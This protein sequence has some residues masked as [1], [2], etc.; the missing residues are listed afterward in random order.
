MPAK[1]DEALRKGYKAGKDIEGMDRATDFDVRCYLPGD[2]LV[3]V[4]R[5]TMANGLETRAPFLDTDLAEFALGLPWQLRFRDQDLKYVLRNAFSH[6]WPPSIRER[7]KQGFGA[8]IVNWLEDKEVQGIVR[9]VSRD[10]GPLISLLPGLK[11]ALHTMSP[12]RRWSVLCLGLWLERH[13]ECHSSL[14]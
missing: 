13:P 3:K 2:I 6:L 10:G 12:Q 11:T 9:R 14:S 1:P 4:D 8:P 5:A 7:K